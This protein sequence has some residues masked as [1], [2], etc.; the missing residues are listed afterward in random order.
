MSALEVRNLSVDVGGKRLLDA[1]SFALEPGE[2][3]ALIGPNGAGKT[4]CL[5][6]ILGLVPSTAER[7][8]VQGRA[9][10]ELASIERARAIA[11]LPQGR[12]VAWPLSAAAT[13]ALGR[14]PH[15]ERGD[16]AVFAHAM[17]ALDLVGMKAFADRDVRTLSGGE[18]ALVLL[19]RALAVEAPV[20]LAD[21]P[22]A[23]L[24]PAH[25]LAVMERL[26]ARA[27]A[28]DAVLVV[29]HDLSLAARYCDRLLLLSG[30]GIAAEG[31]PK[32]VVRGTALEAAYG[33]RFL[34]GELGGNEILLPELQRLE[35]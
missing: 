23:S 29:L 9:I 21:E 7:I 6:A 25:Q 2:L 16:A 14:Y 26:R 24:D 5:R 30:G 12:H 17:R 8:A 1:V 13:V 34:R 15:A 32:E 4:T 11:Y 22:I 28:G 19:A 18:L 20:L 35:I 27:K 3:V 10:K 31:C 33:V